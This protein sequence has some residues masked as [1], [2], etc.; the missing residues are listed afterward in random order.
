M[1]QAF[2]IVLRILLLGLIG[3]WGYRLWRGTTSW[4]ARGMGS[5]LIAALAWQVVGGTL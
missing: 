3:Y 2:L 4:T 1:T 5:V